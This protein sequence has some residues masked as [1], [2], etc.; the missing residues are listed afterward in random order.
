MDIESMNFYGLDKRLDSADYFETENFQTMLKNIKKSI[1][2]GG[3]IALTGIIGMGKTVTLRRLQQA[4]RDEKENKIIISRSLA[5]DRKQVTINTLYNAL[6]TDLATKKDGKI[7]TQA[8][9]RERKFQ[10]MLKEI[11]KP[12]AF[13][14]D[15]AH[16]LH[17]RTMISLKHLVETA[18]D[19]RGTLAIVI[20]GHPKLANDLRNP[21]HE[22]VGART[23]IFELN[24]LGV[25]S[26]KFIEWLFSNCSKDKIKP[27]D[28]MTK[29]AIELFADRLITPLQI[30][31][32]LMRAL[33]KGFQL[34][35]KPITL[36][37][38]RSV[39]SPDLNELE[40]KL[41]RHG[42][43]MSVLCDYFNVRRSEMKAY[44]RGQLPP[45]RQDEINKEVQ[46]LGILV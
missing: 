33:E 2:F 46:K 22:E 24:T 40:P 30:T 8:E 15:E 17:P 10:A 14:I 20:V 42:Y 45:H 36:E 12:I 3:I 21:A 29:E 7:P 43:G 41:I 16:N 34:G 31:H 13:F 38:A 4:L 6:F 28:I 11:N 19:A 27:H 44:F 35:E 23:I 39:L 32:Y 1:S 37:T 18:Q 26:A 9:K 5:S 25:N